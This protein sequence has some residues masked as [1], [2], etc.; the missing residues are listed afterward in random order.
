MSNFDKSKKILLLIIFSRYEVPRLLEGG[1]CFKVTE[2][3]NVKREN[4]VV[5][6]FQNEKQIFIIN[7]PYVIKNLNINNILIVL[8]FG[9]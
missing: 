2:M 3:N 6:F 4:L 7:K 5:F 8:L 9:S 1:A